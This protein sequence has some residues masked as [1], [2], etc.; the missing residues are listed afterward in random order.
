MSADM[1]NTFLLW[2]LKGVE[3]LATAGTENKLFALVNLGAGVAAAY[4]LVGSP[5]PFIANK[6]YTQLAIGYAAGGGGYLVAHMV[7]GA[8]MKI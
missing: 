6:D 8:V 4:Y 2:P 7:T 5:M 3:Q 1:L